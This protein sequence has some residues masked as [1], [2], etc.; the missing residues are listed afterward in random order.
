MKT[1]YSY[2]KRNLI[3]HITIGSAIRFPEKE[4]RA[5]L[6]HHSYTPRAM[7]KHKRSRKVNQRQRKT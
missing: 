6:L 3:S 4:V 2:A 5:W 7:R 1:I